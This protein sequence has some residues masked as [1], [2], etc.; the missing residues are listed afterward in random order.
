MKPYITFRKNFFFDIHIIN[1]KVLSIK[2]KILLVLS[3]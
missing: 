2:I 1:E 3:S